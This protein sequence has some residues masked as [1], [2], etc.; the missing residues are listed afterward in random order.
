MSTK[1]N[2][3]EQCVT[4]P[5]EDFSQA[6]LDE[7]FAAVEG[8]VEAYRD[9]SPSNVAVV[10]EPFAGRGALLDYGE[11]LLDQETTVRHSFTKP[12]C[13][14][15]PG[16]EQADAYI[17]DDCHYLYHRAIGG[18]DALETF[19]ERMAQSDSLFLTAWNRY[20]WRYLAAVRDVDR[21][22]PEVVHV[23]DFDTEALADVVESVFG[24]D[25]PAY[26]ERN[27]EGRIKSVEWV[28]HTVRLWSRRRLTVPVLKLNPEYALS[29]ISRDSHNDTEAVVFEKIRRVAGGNVGVAADC[30]ARSVRNGEIATGDI[31]PLDPQFDLDDGGAMLLRVIVAT[32]SVPRSALE[33]AHTRSPVDSVVQHLVEEG[34]VRIDGD[35]VLLTPQGLRPAVDELRRRRLLW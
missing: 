33:D 34:V 11:E 4:V 16:S 10:A 29:W 13:D 1:G 15:L 25:L 17:V 32:E 7:Q 6:G 35:D 9:G 24:P 27:S 30:W 23:E 14:W 18:F 12:V 26:V 31:E 3:G 19:L 2:Q 22:F 21:T 20:A 5:V 28:R 8:A